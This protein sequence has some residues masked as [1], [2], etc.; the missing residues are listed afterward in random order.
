[1]GWLG[2]CLGPPLAANQDKLY[3][4]LMTRSYGQ[5]RHLW[6]V[7]RLYHRLIMAGSSSEA[8]AEAVGSMLTRATRVP[9]HHCGLGDLLDG[10]RLRAA[11]VGSADCNADFI[12]R[13]LNIRLFG[14]PWH[15][16]LSRQ[17][18]R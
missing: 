14:E 7:L 17:G 10:V 15:F 18:L 4:L 16:H 6:H 11:G 3:K 12:R 2:H 8:L 5:S 13:C 9:G 1:M